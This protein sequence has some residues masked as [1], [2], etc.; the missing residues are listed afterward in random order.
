MT[1]TPTPRR[2]GR[3]E[4]DQIWGAAEAFSVWDN[5][6][7]GLAREAPLAQ[8]RWSTGL[9]RNESCPPDLR[10]DLLS[11][12]GYLAHTCGFM[13]FDGYAFEDARRLL[14]FGVACAEEAND[15]H[16]R[17][18]LLA[19]RARLDT[20]VGDPDDGVT[21]TQLALV[22]S[23][24]LTATEQAML[25]SLEAR[26]LARM[27]RLQDTL[28]AIGRADEAFSNQDVAEDPEWMGYYDAAQHAG[29]V[30][31]ALLD[32]ALVGVTSPEEARARHTVA[33]ETRRPDLAR[34]RALS[35]I[36][37]AKLIV[38]TG[39]P[40]E[41]V[42]IGHAALDTASPIRSRRVAE[43]LA[44]LNRLAAPHGDRA[45]MRELRE[46]LATVTAS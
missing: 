3:T 35:Q 45:D 4:I 18:R 36:G 19:T 42:P 2:V 37:L 13:G 15:W 39:D 40:A 22:R 9:L 14:G 30:G 8:L 43:D 28:A 20:W 25:Y 27:H 31:T 11:A 1:P 17:A 41:A 21:H 32:L 10:P 38:V 26:A 29:D 23:D 46:R 33:I 5:L 6:Y 16:L 44:D 7:G 24:R 12:I 34:S